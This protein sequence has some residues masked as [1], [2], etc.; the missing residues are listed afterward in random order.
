MSAN[1][2]FECSLDY[3]IRREYWRLKVMIWEGSVLEVNDG[4]RFLGRT[5]EDWLVE[6]WKPL[7]LKARL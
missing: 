7:I 2:D 5:I 6:G 3:Y 4:T 1:G